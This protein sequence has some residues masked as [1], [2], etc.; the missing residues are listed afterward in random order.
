MK[1]DKVKSYKIRG[2]FRYYENKQIVEEIRV[3]RTLLAKCAADAESLTYRAL[4][5]EH[6]VSQDGHYDASLKATLK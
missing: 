6:P 3:N 2:E 5:A 1:E 4:K